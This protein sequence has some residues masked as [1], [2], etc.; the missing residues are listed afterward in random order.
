LRGLVANSGGNIRCVIADGAYEGAPVYQA[1]R[2]ARP[3]RRRRRSSS[4]RP[5]PR[6]PTRI[7]RTADV[8]ANVMPQR[9]RP[10]A[11]WL[12]GRATDTASAH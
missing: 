2:D 7:N 6:S 5:S 1:I 3:G 8:S 4:R 11:E 9:L 10:V 12:G